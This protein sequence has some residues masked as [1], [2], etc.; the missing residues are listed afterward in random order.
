MKL[1]LNIPLMANPYNWI[2]LVLMVAIAA[3]ALSLLFPSAAPTNM[4]QA[5]TGAPQ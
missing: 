4:T 1:P 5:T 2:V 3:L